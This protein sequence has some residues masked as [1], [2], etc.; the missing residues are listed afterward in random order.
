MSKLIGEQM[1]F[2]HTQLATLNQGLKGIRESADIQ[3][4]RL[5]FST[6]SE[7]MYALVKAYHP[8]ESELYYQFCPMAKNGDGANW[9]SSTKEIVN[10]YMGQRMPHCGRT[11]EMIN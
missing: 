11:K 7:S 9:L 4:T 8:N 10:P 3:E 5:D 1:D 2:Y 6:I